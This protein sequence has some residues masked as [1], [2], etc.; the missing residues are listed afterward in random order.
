M[1]EIRVGISGW[2]YVPWRNTFYPKG[3][4]Q[5]NKL[6]FASRTI[7]SIEMNGSFYAL[8]SPKATK[9]GMRIPPKN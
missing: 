6:Y 5:K 2:R 9:P 7:N 1:S 3:L 8:Q 4:L